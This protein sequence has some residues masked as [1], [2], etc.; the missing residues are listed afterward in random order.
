MLS[1]VFALVTSLELAVSYSVKALGG[2]GSAVVARV[3]V[4]EDEPMIASV[5]EMA[6]R[7]LGFGTVLAA[8]GSA[9][10]D[11]VQDKVLGLTLGG[12]G[13]VANDVLISR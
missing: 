8:T 3:L 12:D 11:A 10:K 7:F 5:L 6:L 2:D 13:Y 9:A 1:A 4:V